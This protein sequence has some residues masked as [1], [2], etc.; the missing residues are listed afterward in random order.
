VGGH[1]EAGYDRAAA[2]AWVCEDIG[3][4]TL[5]ED[6][7]IAL[8]VFSAQI[9]SDE[10]GL[11]PG[12]ERASAEDAIAWGRARAATVI[13]RCCESWENTFYSAGEKAARGQNGDILPVWP[14]GGLGLQPRRLPGWE[15][16]DRT[17]DDEP[18]EWD[19]VLGT[20]VLPQPTRFAAAFEPALRR[21]DSLRVVAIDVRPAPVA[22]GGYIVLAS[23]T[24][25]VHVRITARTEA[26]ATELAGDAG[27]RAIDAAL[28][29]SAA[30]P[31]RHRVGEWQGD[32]YPTGSI[33]AAYNAG[34][35]E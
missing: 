32:A 30:D 23:D 28:A 11:E 34:L 31:S 19:V 18:I 29:E 9:E 13:V 15:H 3:D 21:E 20:D 25:R 33:A 16:L 2:V 14:K 4:P 5:D 26:E 22:Q 8:G 27:R 35:H 6:D 24:V 1:T 7:Y 12:P 17:L 10:T